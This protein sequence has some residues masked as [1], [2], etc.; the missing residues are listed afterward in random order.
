VSLTSE[1]RDP[2][3]ELAAWCAETLGGTPAVVEQVAAA[4]RGAEPVRPQV[5]E[6]SGRHWA[7]IGGAFGQRVADLVQ[8]APPY[9]ALLGMIRAGWAT[10]GWAHEQAAQYPTHR[11]LPPEY[12][13]RA[14]GIRP[15]ATS[16]LDLG[17][18]GAD[19]SGAVPPAAAGAWAE[20]LERSRAY[21]AAHAPT[22]TLGSAGAEAGLARSSWLLSAAEDIHRSGQVDDR[23]GALFTGGR[24]PSVEQ[25]RGLVD[26][27]Q[28]AELVALSAKLHATGALWDLRKLGGNPASGQPL[29]IA[30]PTIVPQWADA[31]ILLGAVDPETGIGE[32][33]S[34]LVDVKTVISTRDAEKIGRWVWQILL[35]AWLDTADLYRI[36]RVGLLLARHGVLI[37]WPLH[38]LVDQLLG[39]RDVGDHHRDTAREIAGRIITAAGLQFPVA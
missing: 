15:A 36:R 35:Y 12:R 13:A 3:S 5:R 7:E 33:G 32:Q 37:T 24:R 34:T 8:P 31:D 27:R 6:V 19:R 23:L 30:S 10:W 22:G 17:G 39:G 16:W 18:I 26:E 20:L 1:L 14:L 28:V 21:L 4:V 29:G 9:Y 38:H 2:R 25:L 11:D